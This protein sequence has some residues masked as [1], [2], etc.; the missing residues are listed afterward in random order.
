MMHWIIIGFYGLALTFILAYSLVQLQLVIRYKLSKKKNQFT[1]E[2]A[3][4]T[5]WPMATIQLPIYNEKYVLDRLLKSVT[6]LDYPQE[7]LQIQLLDDSTDETKEL[8]AKLVHELFEK[9]FDIQH[10]HRENRIGFKAGALQEGLT[11]AKGDFI[12]IFDADFKPKKDFLKQLLPSFEDP[13]IG[14]VQSRWAHLNEK[15]SLLTKLQAFGLDAHFSVEQGGRNAG[16]HFINFNG[17]AGIWRKET[18]IDAGGWQFDTLTEDLD[19]SYRAQLN[20]WK[21][22]FKEEVEAPAELPAEMNALKNQQ[23]RWNKGAAEC[24]RKN[25]Y[26]VLINKSIRVETKVNAI[27]HLM[28]SAIFICVILLALLSL[29]MMYIKF[30]HPELSTLFNWAGV[31]LITLPILAYFYWTSEKRKHSGVF[32]FMYR[33]SSFLSVSMGMSLHNAIAVVEGYIGR[34]SPF[35]R[36]PKFNLEN[37]RDK[38]LSKNIYLDKRLS[39]LVFL[40]LLL[41]VYFFL[42][43]LLAFRLGDFGLLPFH[44]LLFGGFSFVGVTSI[45]H[46]LRVYR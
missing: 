21:F 46:S 18:I 20:G 35:V 14:M 12:A 44:L 40:E 5:D 24:M 42:G 9:G 3:D 29:P 39:P 43:I 28:N 26:K 10:L 19:L 27:F 31:F 17:T 8:G 1:P 7:K 13:K 32:Q 16:D 15:Y 45:L 30:N 25:L 22:L 38:D 4:G 34:K 41:A 33:F 23:Y 11:K 36:T 2:L 6:E 37:S